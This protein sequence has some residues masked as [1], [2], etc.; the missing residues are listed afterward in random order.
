[1]SS[2]Y[3]CYCHINPPC[4][5]CLEKEE[6]VI[7]GVMVHPDVSEYLLKSADDAYGPICPKCYKEYS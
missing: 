3:Q 1:M 7:C 4:S 5:Y 6:C 2:D